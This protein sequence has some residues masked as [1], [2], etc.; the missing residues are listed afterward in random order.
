MHVSGQSITFPH[1]RHLN[2][3]VR[4]HNAHRPG[5]WQRWRSLH[6]DILRHV[7]ACDRLGINLTVGQLAEELDEALGL[8]ERRLEE[9]VSL[10][11]L[12]FRSDGCIE[13]DPGSRLMCG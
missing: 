12:Q 1:R 10:Q 11:L 8:V 9:L 13:S 3:N 5:V 2:P 6:D 4:A 7:R